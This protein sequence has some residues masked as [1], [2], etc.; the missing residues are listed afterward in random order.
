M[1]KL[2]AGG[3]VKF[4]VELARWSY[5]QFADLSTSTILKD[6]L[7]ETQCN[8]IVAT[9]DKFGRMLACWDEVTKEIYPGFQHG[10]PDKSKISISKL[11]K[12][13]LLTSDT[14]NTARK[15]QMLIHEKIKE[16]EK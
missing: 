16:A 6:E 1:Y 8:L 14:Y 13:G 15:I 5:F 2:L 9:I 4:G 3:A 10:I 11:A 7:S 12:G